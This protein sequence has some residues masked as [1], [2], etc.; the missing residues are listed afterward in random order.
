MKKTGRVLYLIATLIII[1]VLLISGCQPAADGDEE[2]S[3][4]EEKGL[5]LEIKDEGAVA[6]EVNGVSRW[7]NLST[8]VV[9]TGIN[10]GEQVIFSYSET[11]DGPLILSLERD[12]Q[13][14]GY[15]RGE[16]FYN[17]Q[18]DSHS[19][20]IE[21]DGQP[22]AFSINSNFDPNQIKSGSYI[23]FTYTEEE[24]RPLIV[25]VEQVKEPP[26]AE[27]DYLFAE[28]VFIGWID[29]QAVEIKIRQIFALAEDINIDSLEDGTLVAFTYTEGAEAMV[30]ELLIEAE[31]PVE[32]NFIHGTLL[33]RTA[34]GLVEV[35]YFRAFSIGNADLDGVAEEDRIAFT[36]KKDEHRPVLI[37]VSAEPGDQDN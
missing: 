32:G 29:P 13:Q 16:G 17:G 34:S 28:G 33:S 7:F 23:T 10:E 25:A 15:L 20:E 30:I 5:L 26:V 2:L 24:H 27:E 19:V 11:V 4:L 22:V 6:L 18:I 37:A 31:D 12:P 36:Y 3:V 14:T 21:I 35:E 1:A 8:G 9:I